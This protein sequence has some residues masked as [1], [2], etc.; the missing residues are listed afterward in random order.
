MR[1][2]TII[3]LLL[4]FC[5]CKKMLDAG[6]P[7]DKIVSATVY[8][9][10]ATA[11]GVMTGLYYTMSSGG[12]A[13]GNESLS[14]IAGLSADE[15][16][17]VN[18]DEGLRAIYQNALT[19][20]V[21]PAWAKLFNYIYVANS[22]LAGLSNS[23]SL[24]P[25]VKSQL[26]G[27]AYFIRA[28]CYSYLVGLFGDVPLL[29]STDAQN[30]KLAAR[31]NVDKIYEQ[32]VA[33]LLRARQLMND[34]YLRADISTPSTDR[35]RPSKWAVNALLARVYLY[36]KKWQE[37]MAA[38][39]S[40]INNT[41]LF[42]LVPIGSV[43]LQGSKE[44]IWQLQPV[45]ANYTQDGQLFNV[46]RPVYLSPYLMNVFENGD[47]R[48]TSWT[49]KVIVGNSVYYYP[50]KYKVYEGVK[51]NPEYLMV[52]RLGELYLIKAEA[53]VNLG[54][55][56]TSAM[57][58]NAIRE[59]AGLGLMKDTT[60]AALSIAIQHERQVELFAEW[61]HRWFDLKRVEGLQVVMPEVTKW[62]GGNW[63]DYKKLYPI[64]ENE[65]QLDRALVQNTGY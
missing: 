24:T 29:L 38:A 7:T 37:A 30:N 25:A 4:F 54:D 22:A 56:T 16:K 50:Y 41:S 3:F 21:V 46:D 5:G 44:A 61:G 64:P 9:S 58:I 59:R 27:E 1:L 10:D 14:L 47:R 62:K 35:V 2:Y 65:L 51:L 32:M 63:D 6:L 8:A 28:F 55:R 26:M 48:K 36:S 39:D 20:M 17:L 42:E 19:P 49:N 45:V 11:A 23:N 12:P 15:Y 43:F 33:D 52:L 53:A 34:Q 57:C 40:V 60:I 18:S 31:T 13:T